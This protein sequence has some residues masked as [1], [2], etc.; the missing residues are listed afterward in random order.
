MAD[1]VDWKEWEKPVGYDR[2]EIIAEVFGVSVRRVEQLRQDGVIKSDKIQVNGKGKN[3]GK[4]RT[5]TMFKTLPTIIAYIRFLQNQ[6]K[7]KNI[8]DRETQLKE[9]KL[10]AEI[11]L[12]E[13]Q[14]ELHRLKTDIAAGKY[15]S[16]EEVKLD[17][18]RFFTILKKFIL[19]I[20][21]K[22]AGR[23]NG[24]IDS[25]EARVIE[26]DI[27]K[28]LKKMLTDF[29]VAGTVGEVEEK[30]TPKKTTRKKKGITDA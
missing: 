17:Y 5:M 11:A 24:C 16:V 1:T 7:G 18:N 14:G 12:K 8:T 22:V 2:I 9:Q 3:K 10:E 27:D 4:T 23:L 26:R 30:A 29:V 20:P 13:S 28:E 15:I 25:A 6:L 19:G 21:S